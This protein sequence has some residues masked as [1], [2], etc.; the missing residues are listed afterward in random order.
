MKITFIEGKERFFYKDIKSILEKKDNPEYWL[1]TYK[2][3]KYM[4]CYFYCEFENFSL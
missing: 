3:H 4:K 2:Q 1:E